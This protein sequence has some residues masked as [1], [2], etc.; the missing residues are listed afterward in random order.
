MGITAVIARA[1]KK[2]QAASLPGRVIEIGESLRSDAIPVP[3]RHAAAR[4]ADLL[5]VPGATEK[6]ETRRSAR[7]QDTER[8]VV[9]LVADYGARSPHAIAHGAHGDA[10]ACLREDPSVQAQGGVCPFTGHATAVEA[11]E[12][13]EAV[14]AAPAGAEPARIEAREHALEASEQVARARSP[15]LLEAPAVAPAPAQLEAPAR[16]EPSAD[17]HEKSLEVLAEKPSPAKTSARSSKGPAANKPSGGQKKK[18]K[19]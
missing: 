15:E 9:P 11:R 1:K 4:I 3:L 18:K 5:R 8:K 13:S 14:H 7:E 19:K 17:R 10:A 6:A 12:Q 2:V 16:V